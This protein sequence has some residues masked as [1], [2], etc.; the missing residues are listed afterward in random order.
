MPFAPTQLARI[1]RRFG[2]RTKPS[3]AAYSESAHTSMRMANDSI[4]APASI[5]RI[6]SARG[7]AATVPGGMQNARLSVVLPNR[8]VIA[9]RICP[10]KPAPRSAR[11]RSARSS[12]A[13]LVGDGCCAMNSR[14]RDTRD[15]PRGHAQPDLRAAVAAPPRRHRRGAAGRTRR[16]S[17]RGSVVG[18]RARPAAAYPGGLRRDRCWRTGL[19]RL[20]RLG[21]EPLFALDRVI[22][23]WLALT[24]T[25]LLAVP[26]A[27]VTILRHRTEPVAFV[28]VAALLVL[29]TINL[30]RARAHRAALLRRKRELG[31]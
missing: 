12:H 16:G 29:A 21:V 17:R 4:N 14:R 9:C 25:G 28:T 15:E 22:A 27:V 6:R 5:I 20:R 30:V 26:V 31:G 11:S 24:A 3:T 23:A 1:A 7:E 19:G 10:C 18:H 2:S 13:C 8:S